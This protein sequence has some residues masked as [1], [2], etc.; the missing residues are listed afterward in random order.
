MDSFFKGYI[1]TKNK[2]P[3]EKY[4]DRTSFP[5]LA[6]VQKYPEYAGILAPETILVDLD[7]GEQAE[8]LMKVVEALQLNCR[9]YQTT[10]GKHFL[11][12]NSKIQK[13][14]TKSTLACG[15]TA[16]IKVGFT[17]AIEVLKFDGKERFCEWDIEEGQEYEEIPLFL[18]P[19]K[20]SADFANMEAGE[21]RN[22]ALF[23]YILTLQSNKFTV[24][25]I[26]EIIRLINRFILKDPLS[27]DELEIILRDEAFQKPV[28]YNG[29]TFLFDEFGNYLIQNYHIK[30]INNQLH[31][32]QNGSYLPGYARIENIM[33]ELIANLK[34]TARKEVLKYLEVKVLENCDLAPSTVIAFRNGVL[35]IGMKQNEDGDMVLTKDEFFPPSPDCV[36]TNKINWD[37]NPAAYDALLDQTL[38]KIACYDPAIRAL[39]EEAAGYALFRRNELGKAFFLTGTGSNGK[40]T[41]LETLEYMLGEDNVSNLDLKK[42]PDRFSTVM[43][44]GKLANIGD[45]ISDEFV[46]D[47][48]LFKKVVTGNRISAEYKGQPVFQFSPYAKLYFSA[49]NIPRMGKGRDWEAI[50]RRM[51]IIPF[52]AKFSPADPD[53][54]PFIGSKLKTQEAMEYFITLG[55]NALKRILTRREFTTSPNIQAELDE[56]EESNNPILIFCKELS[57][58]GK[59]IENQPVQEIYLNYAGWCAVSNMKPMSRAE[60]T[61]AIK[62]ALNLE[63]VPRKV[64]GKSMRIFAKR[65]E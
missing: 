11:F 44:F 17:N 4:K 32:Y 40:S 37:Y 9:V 18:Y 30:R 59:E 62:K 2:H 52:N 64:N 39:L 24:E 51:V 43:L 57:E 50:K 28:F 55:V 34:D 12:R 47:T 54:V 10:R 46:V 42:L 8:I 13:C 29:R 45:D 26:R 65:E 33:L 15:L 48:S 21:G 6:D 20:G 58:D 3:A 19:I 5:S 23:N 27:S 53:F 1:R 38:N 14:S 36:V 41:Y 7:N 16:D 49:N 31:V 35:S 56:Y 25:E 60:F 63:S 61:K 22:Q